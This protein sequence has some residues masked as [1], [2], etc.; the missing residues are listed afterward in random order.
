MMIPVD[1]VIQTVL[2]LILT[3]TGVLFIAGDFKVRFY[4]NLE[5]ISI[6]EGS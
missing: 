5:N 6:R 2:S 1:I 4:Y 3:M